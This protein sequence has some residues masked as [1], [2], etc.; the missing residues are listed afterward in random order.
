MATA[1]SFPSGLIA[2]Y[3][4]SSYA[5]IRARMQKCHQLSLP[6]ANVVH[7][8]LAK[9]ILRGASHA[10]H[11]P[12]TKLSGGM[13]NGVKTPVGTDVN[14]PAPHAQVESCFHASLLQVPKTQGAILSNLPVTMTTVRTTHTQHL[15]V[16]AQFSSGLT[17]RPVTAPLCECKWT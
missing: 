2:R 7:F 14:A 11:I 9:R 5:I 3:Y 10:G 17:H 16:T 13:A 8:L 6:E 12:K 4:M 15:T 1:S